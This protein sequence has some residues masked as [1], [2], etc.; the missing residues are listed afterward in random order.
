MTILEGEFREILR[1][2]YLAALNQEIPGDIVELSQGNFLSVL[3]KALDWQIGPF[4]PEPNLGFTKVAQLSDPTGIGWT[5]SSIFN[6]SIIEEADELHLFYRAAVK[7]E[8]LG[9]RIG[10]AIYSP[11]N[12]WVNLND[13]AIFPSEP[14]EA[15]STEDPKVYR[16]APRRFIMFYNGVW[17]AD[18][19]A[20]ATYQKP[21]GDIACD[22]KYA[23]SEDLISWEKRGLVVPYEISRLWAKGAVIPR[24]G[25]GNAVKINGEYLMFLSE[26]CGGSQFIGRSSDAID[27]SFEQETYL[28]LPP[29]MGRHIYEVATAVIN[30]DR[31]ILDFMY[32]DN[33]GKHAG[34][35]ALY[36]VNNPRKPLDLAVGA[37][38]S[39]G[40][41]I[42]Y[43]NR[44]TMAQ[45][46]DA[47]SG[48]EQIFF[49][50]S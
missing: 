16:I 40:G 45:G 39:W 43:R 15:L 3:E 41:L 10:H 34:A 7:K 38:L 37:T 1:L 24:D 23:V 33:D 47:P 22:I 2:N 36:D 44:W 28:T 5:S 29:Q 19:E 21:F 26:G 14:N 20:I 46:W 27:W 17:R 11:E 8:S 4:Q 18:K 49:Y 50:V 35:Q 12:G 48:T 42:K 6:P 31:M 9:S 32:Q 25:F 30:G 13:P